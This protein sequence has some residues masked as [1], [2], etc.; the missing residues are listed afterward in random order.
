[1]FESVVHDRL[2][3]QCIENN[4]ITEKQ[5]AYLKGDSTVSQLLY[6]VRNI[7]NS[8]GNKNITHGLFLD[9]RSAFDKVWHNRLLEKLAHIGV[10]DI[11]LNTVRSYL[12]GRRQVVVVNGVKSETL[13]VKGFQTWPFTFYHLYE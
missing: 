7:R 5:A 8:W 1:M 3:K 9:V 11:F 10:E 6:I 4:I 2:V 12:T 13:E